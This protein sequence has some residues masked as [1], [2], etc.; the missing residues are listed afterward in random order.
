MNKEE[1]RNLILTAVRAGMN[2]KFTGLN[3]TFV[4]D[5]LFK[6]FLELHSIE[7]EEFK[8]IMSELLD[9]GVV[10]VAGDG[11]YCTADYPVG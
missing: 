6:P 10:V 9:S 5:E 7:F 8:G 11:G 4:T 3:P 1:K 2:F